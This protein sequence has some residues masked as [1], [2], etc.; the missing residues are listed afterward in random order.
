VNL[1]N[2]F[3]YG[4]LK[5]FE[6]YYFDMEYCDATLKTWVDRYPAGGFDQSGITELTFV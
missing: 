4:Q 6:G 5:I 3:R 2:V 1:V